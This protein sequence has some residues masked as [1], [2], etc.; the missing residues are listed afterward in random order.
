[1]EH[2]CGTLQV[3]GVTSLV[4]CTALVSVQLILEKAKVHKEARGRGQKE[5]SVHKGTTPPATPI[6]INSADFIRNTFGC[7]I[8][9][10]KHL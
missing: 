7:T 10:A 8:S 9:H 1:M 3:A 2:H 5:Q 6:T 4:P